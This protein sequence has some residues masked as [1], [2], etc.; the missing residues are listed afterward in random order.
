MSFYPTETLRIFEAAFGETTGEKVVMQY[1][2]HSAGPTGSAG[3]TDMVVAAS[4]TG[5]ATFDWQCPINKE[6]DIRRVNFLILDDTITA[7]KFGGIGQLPN[8]CLVELLASGSGEEVIIDF[9]DGVPIRSNAHFS[10]LAGVDVDLGPSSDQVAVRWTL[11]NVA[12]GPLRMT[13][14]QKIRFTIQD[15]MTGI[16]EFR[17]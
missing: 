13:E 16:D 10:L 3:F 9:C 12:G 14:G 7:V 4:V 17:V 5:S 1:L 2:S 11:S 6:A 8:G 15:D